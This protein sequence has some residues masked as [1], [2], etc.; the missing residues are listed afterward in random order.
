MSRTVPDERSAADSRRSRL[1][2]MTSWPS[3]SSTI[4]AIRV[5]P[6]DRL[7][8]AL[9]SLTS[10][11]CV[12]ASPLTGLAR[13]AHETVTVTLRFHARIAEL[14]SSGTLES[15]FN[16]ISPLSP[17]PPRPGV[18]NHEHMGHVS[19]VPQNVIAQGT[20]ARTRVSSR[21]GN[22]LSHTG[23]SSPRGTL[24]TRRYRRLGS[25]CRNRENSNNTHS[26]STHRPREAWADRQRLGPVAPGLPRGV[27]GTPAS[28][29][30]ASRRPR[31]V[32]GPEATQPLS[33]V[34]K[35]EPPI[36]PRS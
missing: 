32:C 14:L 6:C 21:P 30:P 12:C 16:R 27:P 33:S 35:Y 29:W 26:P 15:P 3:E 18:Y 17:S 28:R 1:S 13:S 36:R 8:S 2:T 19:G 4:D 5:K 9:P 34:P 7:A 20:R 10:G 23:C 22:N 11:T 31:L 24:H 25:R